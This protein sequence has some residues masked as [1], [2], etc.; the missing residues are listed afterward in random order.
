MDKI[1]Q[2]KNDLKIMRVEV[3]EQCEEINVL[4]LNIEDEEKH[5]NASR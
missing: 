3:K 5:K 2:L 1:E 4:K